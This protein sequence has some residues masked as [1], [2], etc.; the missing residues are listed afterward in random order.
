MK[1]FKRIDLATYNAPKC[2]II[3]LLKDEV[4]GSS[5][6]NHINNLYGEINEDLHVRSSS[7]CSVGSA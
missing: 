7:R 6:A 2:Y 4:L 3:E 5:N 1:T